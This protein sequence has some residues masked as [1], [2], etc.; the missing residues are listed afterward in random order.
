MQ[1][2]ADRGDNTLCDLQSLRFLGWKM[3]STIPGVIGLGKNRMR[4]ELKSAWNM[5]HSP[6]I[7]FLLFLSVTNFFF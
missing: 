2:L 7:R 6:Q 3:G 5:G 1:A 4:C